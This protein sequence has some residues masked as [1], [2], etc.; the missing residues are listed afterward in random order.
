M[1]EDLAPG[2]RTSLLAV[3]AEL[4]VETTAA[5]VVDALERDGVRSILLKGPSF[6]RWLYGPNATR[7]SV[8]VDLLISPGDRAAAEGTVTRLGFAPFPSNVPAEDERRHAY[9]WDRDAGLIG[10]DLHFTLPGVAVSDEDAWCAL[11]GATER[12]TVGGREIE[13]LAPAS[14]ALHVAIHA[15]QHGP[16][17]E[18]PMADLER[19][20]EQ[21]RPELWEEAAALARRLEAVPMFAAGL[22]L[23][24]KGRWIARGLRVDDE[25]TVEAALR[26]ST[27]PDLALGFERLASRPG[28]WPK[29]EFAIRKLVPP[30]AWML[31]CVPL[32]R[33]GRLGLVAAYLW[34]PLWLL[35]RVGPALRAWRRARRQ[36]AG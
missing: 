15:A 35:R 9:C 2:R 26:A 29:V 20:L 24:P 21:I 10:V 4:V 13:V 14:R 19:A 25:R 32:A 30:R 3:A 31:S 1:T 23:Q 11:T 33:R 28:L 27:P 34:R 5:E 6:A 16:G 18:G 22:G 7:P 8:D 12:L 36:A 17:F